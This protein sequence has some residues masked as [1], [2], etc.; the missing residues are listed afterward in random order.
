MT[1]V[2]RRAGLRRDD[3]VAE[4]KQG[5]RE[6]VVLGDDLGFIEDGAA[7][8]KQALGGGP[9]HVAEGPDGEQ[10]GRSG[11]DQHLAL[12]TVDVAAHITTRSGGVSCRWRWASAS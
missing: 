5:E 12:A 4:M 11:Q 3:L 6:L 8:G 10:R 1:S 7:R 2:V 9:G